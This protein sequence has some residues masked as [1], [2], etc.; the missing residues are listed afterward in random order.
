MSKILVLVCLLFILFPSVQADVEDSGDPISNE[1]RCDLNSDYDFI[2]KLYGKCT[3]TSDVLTERKKCNCINEEAKTNYLLRELQKSTAAESTTNQEAIRNRYEERFYYSYSLMLFEE[4]K[5]KKFLGLNNGNQKILTCSPEQ[6]SKSISDDVAEFNKKKKELLQTRAKDLKSL[7]RREKCDSKSRMSETRCLDIKKQADLISSQLSSEGL[8]EGQELVKKKVNG[9]K[10][11]SFKED[12]IAA[13]EYLHFIINYNR[14]RINDTTSTTGEIE[15]FKNENKKLGEIVKQI[16]LNPMLLPEDAIEVIMSFETKSLNDISVPKCSAGD[17]VCECFK[18]Q[19]IKLA[20][21]SRLKQEFSPEKSCVSEDEFQAFSSLPPKEL[22]EE[23]LK[24]KLT[25]VEFLNPGNGKNG[26][27]Y[28]AKLNFLRFNPVL[29]KLIQSPTKEMS[30]IL[31]QKF[32]DLARDEIAAEKPAQKLKVF[33]DFLKSEDK[34]IA[35]IYNSPDSGINSGKVCDSLA[36]DFTA[37]RVADYI[38]DDGETI[39]GNDDQVEN[40]LGQIR[41]C[42]DLKSQDAS[43]TNFA[44]TMRIDPLFQ[45]APL[46]LKANV[47]KQATDYQNFIK[48]DCKD[49]PDFRAKS[50]VGLDVE[51]CRQNYLAQSNLSGQVQ[52]LNQ[53][54]I[55]ANEPVTMKDLMANVDQKNDNKV[56]RDEYEKNV[57]PKSQ[58]PV[59]A[60][61]GHED[62]FHFESKKANDFISN[63]RVP[64]PVRESFDNM[65]TLMPTTAGSSKNSNASES[66]HSLGPRSSTGQVAPQFS[67]VSSTSYAHSSPMLNSNQPGSKTTFPD[68][69]SEKSQVSSDVTDKNKLPSKPAIGPKLNS[70]AI[71]KTNTDRELAEVRQKLK[72]Q[73]KLISDLQQTRSIASPSKLDLPA[74]SGP[75]STNLPIGVGGPVMNTQIG[76]SSLD[77]G[78]QLNFGNAGIESKRAFSATSNVHFLEGHVNPKEFKAGQSSHKDLLVQDSSKFKLLVNDTK[79][80]ESYL[81]KELSGMVIGEY[82]LVTIIN[83]SS[84]SSIPHMIL[85][86]KQNQDGSFDIQSVP[87]EVPVRVATLQSLRNQLPKP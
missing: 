44:E 47:I 33:V 35:K 12:P 19:N 32:S 75:V 60:F 61:K 56:L 48:N 11:C 29:A 22:F 30:A 81:K 40:M 37:I 62:D 16:H 23:M 1:N 27:N 36:R 20:N 70:E 3:D 83:K 79:A 45:L 63:Y 38:P 39:A 2:T 25:P 59:I 80:L 57:K 84:G 71:N 74:S 51:V 55:H 28:E 69:L 4:A 76:S 64:K 78:A 14:D 34:G 26:P 77:G 58:P 18:L 49:Y 43:L 66:D 15:G 72:E 21:N 54:G 31:N 50:C 53:S 85:R 41:S 24:S 5:Q 82:K 6:L 46:D 10:S 42:E 86:V 67:K 65:S 73:D 52:V 9:E 13:K 68:A 7:I 8:V 87:E 17:N